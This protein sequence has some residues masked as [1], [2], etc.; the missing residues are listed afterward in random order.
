[1]ATLK[2]W[3]ARSTLRL[4]S[5][6]RS[7]FTSAKTAY[8]PEYGPPP[9]SAG[10]SQLRSNKSLSPLQ[11]FRT[12]LDCRLRSEKL[13]SEANVGGE[14]KLR[15]RCGRFLR[16]TNPRGGRKML[17]HLIMLGTRRR[18]EIAQCRF[19]DGS[20]ATTFPMPCRPDK[21]GF[22]AAVSSAA[23]LGSSGLERGGERAFRRQSR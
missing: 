20:R 11:M 2:K 23:S 12:C 14:I 16:F 10:S 21:I 19:G 6:A 9:K 1:M 3:L 7:R 13:V 15:L 18:F 17:E 5:S 8:A 22:E 4:W